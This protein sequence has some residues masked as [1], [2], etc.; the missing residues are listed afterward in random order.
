MILQNGRFGNGK[1]VQIPIIMFRLQM[2][3]STAWMLT[4]KRL[5]PNRQHNR[6]CTPTTTLLGSTCC[7]LLLLATACQC[8]PLLATA[9]H[10]LLLLTTCHYMLLL[11]MLVPSSSSSAAPLTLMQSNVYDY[12]TGLAPSFFVPLA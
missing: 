5:P 11:S 10:C 1:F 9:C 2:V 7:F 4:V 3:V 12:K 6:P 8:L